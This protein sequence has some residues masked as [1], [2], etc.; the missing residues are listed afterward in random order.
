MTAMMIAMTMTTTNRGLFFG[1]IAVTSA[2]GFRNMALYYSLV[3]FFWRNAH[4]NDDMM[5]PITMMN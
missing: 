2:V 3:L 4:G 1:S 5:V